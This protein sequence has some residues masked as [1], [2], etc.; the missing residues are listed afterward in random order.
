MQMA[1]GAERN[2]ADRALRNLSEYCVAQFRKHYLHDA[3]AAVGKHQGKRQFER[4]AG[5]VGE[6]VDHTAIEQRHI[7]GGKLGAGQQP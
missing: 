4:Q 1:K 2:I 5:R 3:Q 7:H 6:H